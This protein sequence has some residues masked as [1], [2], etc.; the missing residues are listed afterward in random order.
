LTTVLGYL[1]AVV[2][3]NLLGIPIRWGA[4]GLTASAGLA[5]WVEF[6]LL[7]SKLNRRIGRTGLPF[8]FVTKLWGAAIV[9]AAI[10]WGIKL[11]LARIHPLHPIPAAVVILGPYG[12]SYFLLAAGLGV[13][14]ASSVIAKFLKRIPGFKR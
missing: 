11:G 1:F 5:G 10:G 3:P 8:G 2:V 9:A 6:M 13:N 14:E 12:V 7:R 4:V